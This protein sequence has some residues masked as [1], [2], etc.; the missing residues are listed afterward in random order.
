M[1]SLTVC[2][3]SK[4]VKSIKSWSLKKVQKQKDYEKNR[5][6]Q[7]HKRVYQGKIYN[8]NFG[9]NL[10]YEI[11]KLRPALVISSE[12][13]NEIPNGMA[14]VIPLT[15]NVQIKEDGTPVF[16]HHFI[17]EKEKFGFLDCDSTLKI[18]QIRSVANRRIDVKHLWGSLD[19]NTLKAVKNK[20]SQFFE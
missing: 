3:D 10:G 2:N 6:V 19:E 14:V 12:S 15:K 20:V 9:S 16:K 18:D 8:V 11:D 1:E 5:Q 7:D 13:Y 4:K 17:L